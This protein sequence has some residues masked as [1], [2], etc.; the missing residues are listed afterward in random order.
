MIKVTFVDPKAVSQ[1]AIISGVMAKERLTQSSKALDKKTKGGIA[2]A[3]KAAKFSGKHGEVLP[4]YA[5]DGLRQATVIMLGLGEG[6]ALNNLK[7]RELGAAVMRGLGSAGAAEATL[8]FDPT[9][10]SGDKLAEQ[11]AQLAMGALL[12]SYKFDKYFTKKDDEKKAAPK[13]LTVQVTGAAAARK[14]FRSLQAIADGLEFSRN[15]VSEPANILYP[16]SMAK[17]CT[18]LRKLG[19]AVQ[20]LGESQMQRLNMGALLGVGQ[21]SARDSQLVIMQWNGAAK[22]KK[23][24]AFVG[25][26]VTFDTGGIS[27]KPSGGME[28]MKWDMGGAGAV[29]GAMHA[30]AARKAK[31]NAVG[32]VGLVEN[33]PSS[34]AQRPGDVVTTMSKQTIEVINTDAEGRLVLADAIWYTQDKF[35]PQIII[36][37]ATLTGAIMVALGHEYAGLFSNNDAL[38]DKLLAAGDVVGEPLWRMPLNEAYDKQINSDIADMK[39]VGAGRWAG[40]S[41]AAALLA[42]FTN[43]VPWAHLDIAGMAWAYQAKKTMDK[44]ATGF[45]V[46]LLDRLVADNYE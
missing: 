24:V 18:K 25:K 20:I 16:E 17:E 9:G 38:A 12:K 43:D 37:L 7:L 28:D 35:K 4:V 6:K 21:G 1:G 33:M 13:K 39:N 31:V 26:G 14:A 42:R 8:L 36:D 46:Q 22:S 3:V 30:L 44:G 45:G 11:A 27:I 5:P 34:T 29:I 23:P 32:V 2:R 19:V 40:S 41:T 15:L 10:V